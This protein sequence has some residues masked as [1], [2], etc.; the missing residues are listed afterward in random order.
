MPHNPTVAIDAT[1]TVRHTGRPSDKP[2]PSRPPRRQRTAAPLAAAVLAALAAAAALPAC[3]KDNGR[4]SAATTTTEASS[5]GPTTT[6]PPDQTGS[7][8]VTDGIRIIVVSSQPDRASGPEA[9]IR[10]VPARDQDPAGLQVSLGAT[11][12]TGQLTETDD[13]TLEGVV[14]GLVEGTNTLTATDGKTTTTQRIRSWPTAGPMISGPHLALLAC[15]TEAAGLGPATDAD[16]S[17]PTQVTWSYVTT[18]NTVVDLPA[19]A[20]PGA[21]P[22]D[23]AT[24][25]SGPF[26]VRHEV[27]VRNRSIY[28]IASLDPSAGRTPEGQTPAAGPERSAW[29][30]RLIHRF[31]DGCGATFG[32]GRPN[33]AALA[34]DLLAQGYIVTSA[35]FTSGAVLCNDVVA[36]ETLMMVKERVIEA[37]GEPEATIGQG[38]GFGGALVHLV[39]QN[40][41]GLL[42]GAAVVDPLPD[43]ITAASG[44]A[45]CSL[46]QAFYATPAGARLTPEQRQAIDGHASP[47]TCARWQSAAGGLVDP[48]VGCDPAISPDQIW[49]TTNPAGVRCTLAD[50]NRNQFGLDPATSQVARPFDNVGVQYGLEALQAGTIDIETF[51]TLNEAVGGYDPDGQPQPAR[52]AADPIAI[53][54]F[55]ETGRVSAG[56]GDQPKVPLVE[57]DRWDDPS[58]AIGDHL[59]PFSL[60]ARVLLGG[61][62]ELAP[63]L[64]I[65][66]RPATTPTG[67]PSPVVEAVGVVDAWLG[68]LVDSGQAGSRRERLEAARPA[69][70]IDSCTQADGKVRFDVH[71]N[72]EDQPCATEFPTAGDPRMAAGGPLATDVLKCQLRPLDD[73]EYGAELSDDQY[74]RLLAVFPDGVCDWAAGGVGQTIPSMSD[75]SFEDVEVPADLA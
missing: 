42:D 65:W 41:P 45:E 50:A 47:T 20:G 69:E 5:G 62:V 23:I 72:D 27:G 44:A 36:A 9:R 13:G 14:V 75:R 56:V 70:G 58:G 29:N 26:V 30:G 8:P 46:L 22:A 17:A 68:D 12:V 49:S 4:D 51:V 39:L 53:Q 66:T 25:D 63:G 59:R 24:I 2:R 37:F 61:P 73:T 7:D 71:A 34:P 18:A 57:V 64:A 38:A 54:T 10:V 28:E 48:T 11:E 74:L 33:V 6:A 43:I 31:G 52:T 40:Y 1:A 60:R 55:Y 19:N 16:C 67:R 21:W 15:A 3:S 35:S 32:Q